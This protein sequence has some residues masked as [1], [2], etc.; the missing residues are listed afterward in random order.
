MREQVIAL[1]DHADLLPHQAD[2][3][4]AAVHR[5]AVQEDLPALDVLQRIDAA[6]QRALSAA[7]RA[8]HHDDLP[9]PDRQVQVLQDH[10]PAE[11][12]MKVLDLQYFVF[13][14]RILNLSAEIFL[15]TQRPAALTPSASPALPPGG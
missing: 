9:F 5:L 7:G 11:L 14:I 12:F 8:D 6:K 10:A 1:E 13:H 15:L 3:L 2:V 4:R